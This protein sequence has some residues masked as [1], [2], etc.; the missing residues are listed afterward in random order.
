M[1]SAVGGL[2]AIFLLFFSLACGT[3]S[4]TLTG[5]SPD[6]CAM[7]ASNSMSSVGAS[8]GSGRVAV[9]AARECTWSVASN[10]P[11]I[12]FSTPTG[13]QGNGTVD[14]V[15]AANPAT[16]GRR[17]GLV[18]GGQTLEVVQA[19]LTCQFSLQPSNHEVGAEGGS[20]SFSVSA[21]ESCNWTA[22]ASHDWITVSTSGT[23]GGNGTVNFTV[24]SNSGRAREGAITVGG[25]AF[26]ILQAAPACRAQLSE[27]GETMVGAGGTGSV[28]IAIPAGCSWTATSAAPWVSITAG[29]SGTGNGTV[30]FSVQANTGPARNAILT[31]AGQRFT[32]T[33]LQAACN[34]S[35]N[36]S[37]RSFAVSG[38][39]DTVSVSTNSAC[40]WNTSDVPSWVTGIPASGTGA[41]TITFTV[42]ANPGPAREAQIIIGGQT[43]SVS[44]AA[45]CSYSL[46]PGSHDASAAGGASSFSI[47]TAPGC[48]WTTSGVPSWITGVPG[49][50][51]GPQ[52]I[53]FVVAATTGGP[54]NAT[55][56][57]AG[58]S[59]SV[60]QSAGCT[61]SLNPT[62]HNAAAGGGSSS[63]EV[64]TSSGC[65]W[66]TSN[67]PA[68]ITGMP[69]NGSGTQTINFTVGA[70]SGSPRSA[71]IT[72]A[73]QTFAV[74]QSS[75]CSYSL[76]PTSHN[77]P[78]GGGSSSVEVA[79]SSGCNWDTSNVPSWMT[80]I[81]GNGSGTQTITFTV[82]ANTGGPRSAN[83]SVAGQTFAVS[84]ATGCTY[85]LNPTS[86][87]AP[88]AGGS[89]SF[90]I[91]TTSGCN[92][93][94]TNVP[95]WVSGIPANGSGTL[96]IAFTV[97]ANT[98][99][100]RNANINIGGQ[101][102]A[103]SQASGCTYAVS[104]GSLTFGVLEILPKDV[105]LTTNAGCPW[106]V[107]PS[108]GW[109]VVMSDTSGNGPATIRIRVD[110]FVALPPAQRSG[111]V[112]VGG[113]TIS[114]T[115][116]IP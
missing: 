86:H 32:V 73:G 31:I 40:T 74:S 72:I 56:T 99:P 98:G 80:G 15:V 11:W 92:W 19:A 29:A 3:S 62:G 9:A 69:A 102:F 44:Q 53:N 60:N 5:P 104:P 107:T 27:A 82:A 61:Y 65:N 14:Y 51:T 25:Q 101:T 6:R 113:Q 55:F 115:Q 36:P 71:N 26:A 2:L 84:Q 38:G 96:A 48:G 18:V 63:V 85:S 42:A 22:S 77:A 89:S 46:A 7:T 93:D 1:K 83:I 105:S 28:N 110:L 79:T 95:A 81:P 49:S 90:E 45:G 67:V 4:T 35:I 91:A 94:A 41:Q 109:I 21:P 70:N 103:V 34:Y 37:S 43:F 8:G 68:W 17:G 50:G 108:D 52:T 54:R 88:A 87:S 24:A 39:Q 33:Q 12:T 112:A 16:E 47:N 111:S 13:G 64:A 114:I 23:Q 58:Q 100:A 10:V 66:D 57:I 30:N 78:A 59:F 76:N 106:N 20:G 97:A 75:G 116:T